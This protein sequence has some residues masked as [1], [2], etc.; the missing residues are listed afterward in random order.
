ME[1]TSLNLSCLH[2]YIFFLLLLTLDTIFT[3]LNQVNK[4][5]SDPI[6][7]KGHVGEVTA[8]DWYALRERNSM[9]CFF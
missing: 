2:L 4:P 5:E 7:L 8:V 1:G 9:C 6:R 3:L